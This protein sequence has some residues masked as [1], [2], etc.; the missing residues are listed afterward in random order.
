MYSDKQYGFISGRSTSS[1][2]LTVLDEWTE[3]LDQGKEIDCIYMDYQK[4]FESVPH[5]RLMEK[6]KCYK[7]DNLTLKWIESFLYGRKQKVVLNGESSKWEPVQSGI[8]QGSVL[9]PTLFVMY[10]NDLPECVKSQAYLFADDTKIFQIISKDEDC[11]Q[12]QD[13]LDT[14]SEWSDKWLLKFHPDK[15]KHV[16]IGKKRKEVTYKLVGKEVNKSSKEKDIGV[17]I[18]RYET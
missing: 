18:N 15:C 10:I 14:V 17:I 4:A 11:T 16:H 6:L 13:D 8:P 9:G 12:L 2:L 1:Q 3:A 7:I 5:N